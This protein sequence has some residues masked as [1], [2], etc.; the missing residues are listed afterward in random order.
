VNTEIPALDSEVNELSHL[1]L[2]SESTQ[3]IDLQSL[4]SSD[5]SQ[6]GV[7]DL[8]DIAST[9]FGKLLDALP[10]PVLLIDKWFFVVFVN[11]SCEKL[12]VDYKEIHGRR[13]TDLLANPPDAS[14]ATVLKNKTMKLLE[15]V[16]S[17]RSPQR[18]EAILNIGSQKIWARL[19]LRTV[20]LSSDRHIMVIIEDITSERTHQRTSQK[21]EQNLRMSLMLLKERL[22]RVVHDLAD[23]Q[24][25][26]KQEQA[27]HEETRRCLRTL[28]EDSGNM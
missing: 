4:F 25:K 26:L 11:Q 5:V 12:S 7:F 23:T 2:G 8:R 14:R 27:T 6:T 1:P 18:A 19:N 17:D 3:T 16:F 28:V 9:S 20:R 22:N 24:L 21:D 13:F 10:V 15:R